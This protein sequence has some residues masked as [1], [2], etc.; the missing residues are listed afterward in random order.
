MRPFY[1]LLL[2][3]IACISFSSG[4]ELSPPE[5]IK[6]KYAEKSL[7]ISWDTVPGAIGYNIYT[8]DSPLNSK[9]KRIKINK[10]LVTSGTHFT[11]IWHFE[12]GEQVRKIKGYTHYIAVTSVFEVN[13]KNRE[14]KLSNEQS[15]AYFDGFD[16]I[17]TRTE[18]LDILQES[19]KTPLL[20][21]VKYANEKRNS[22]PILRAS[23]V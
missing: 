11:Y 16:R 13:G 21:V 12:N 2:S 8:S 7:S 18:I 4:G 6:I 23:I 22:T 10:K 9:A 20:P 17:N 15:N 5:N 14:S 19:Q 3:C 1:I